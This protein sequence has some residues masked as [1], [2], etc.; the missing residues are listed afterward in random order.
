M[1]PQKPRNKFSVLLP[2]DERYFLK[3]QDKSFRDKYYMY[4][5]SKHKKGEIPINPTAYYHQRVNLGL[6]PFTEI[7]EKLG[8]E[9]GQ[10]RTIYNNAMTK[11]RNAML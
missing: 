6:T 5:F 11:I 3:S 4:V 1:Q 2:Q 8:L 7:A 9:V 10:V